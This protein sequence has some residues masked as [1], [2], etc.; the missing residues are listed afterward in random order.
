MEAHTQRVQQ[1][2]RSVTG[3]LVLVLN[4]LGENFDEQGKLQ[5]LFHSGVCVGAALFAA[6]VP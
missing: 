2:H 3:K 4:G 6:L 1:L 5:L